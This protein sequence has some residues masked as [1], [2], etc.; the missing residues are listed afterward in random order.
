MKNVIKPL[1]K[2][3]LIPLRLTAAASAA[4]AGIHKKISGSDRPS[5]SASHN[6]TILI[7][8]HDEMKKIIEIVESLEDFSL[9]PEGVGEAIQ[10]EAKEQRGQFLSLLLGTLGASLLGDILTGRGIN[11]AGEGVIRAGY[12]NKKGRKATT[13]RQDYDNKMDFQC[14]LIF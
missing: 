5:F 2:S 9:L 13:K 3:V 7:I 12:G 6:N 8:S 11:R 14:R 4:D 10:N 1:A